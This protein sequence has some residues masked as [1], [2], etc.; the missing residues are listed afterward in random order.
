[1]RNQTGQMFETLEPRV[2]LD[3]AFAS[4][5]IVAAPTNTGGL[6]VRAWAT[7]GRMDSEGIL[8]EARYWV[9]GPGGRSFGDDRLWYQRIF[10]LDGDGRQL[11]QRDEAFFS[12]RPLETNGSQFLN[13]DGFPAGWW[14]A[15]NSANSEELELMAEIITSPS[16]NAFNASYRFSAVGFDFVTGDFFSSTG[17]LDI[18]I[19]D[20]EARWNENNGLM[21]RRLSRLEGVGGNS[22]RSREGDYF[23]L[24]ADGRTVLFADLNI[25]NNVV[26]IGIATR[27]VSVDS[28]QLAGG[29]NWILGETLNGG[30]N[31]T[32]IRLDLRS[33][34]DYRI[35]DLDDWDDGRFTTLGRGRWIADGSLLELRGDNGGQ[36]Y[37]FRIGDEAR[38]LLPERFSTPNASIPLFGLATR[39]INTLPG[40][41]PNLPKDDVVFSVPGP[42]QFNRPGVYQLEDDSVWY[43]IDLLI[44]AGGPTPTGEVESWID[45]NRL[46]SSAVAITD[47]GLALYTEN[48]DKSWTVRILTTEIAGAVGIASELEVMLDPQGLAHVT[49]LSST[50]EVL[51]YSQS[52]T[53]DSSG[54]AI[55]TFKNISAQDLAPAGLTTP[56]FTGLVSYATSWGGLNIAGLDSEGSIWSVWTAPAFNGTWTASN[57]T[58]AYGA[59]PLVGGLTVYLTSWQ[60]INI[61]GI[62]ADGELKVTWWVPA[63]GGTWAQNSLTELTGGPALVPATVTSYVSSWDGLNVAGI[64]QATGKL[65]VYWWSPAR[66]DLGW[67]IASLS[68]AL[69]AGSI[70]IS[71]GPLDG[72]AARDSSLNVFGRSEDGSFLRV[73]WTPTTGLWTSLNL[74][75][76]AVAR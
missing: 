8:T 67:A 49:G 5:G 13:A 11:R 45:S 21:P 72:I 20:N 56:A 31:L 30:F 3:N 36:N 48:I 66:Q 61:A 42:V 24:S 46:A 70:Q 9:D 16:Q 25:S 15:E 54:R 18:N 23:Y 52:A 29:Y 62:D 33:N 63:F 69:P 32:Q 38:T 14:F 68:D 17:N 73:F 76:A 65:M 28:A 50:G 1:M 10:K 39:D 4:V 55:W 51:Y 37:R 64:D 44:L 40:G 71:Q 57:L 2:V 58:T 43:A 53:N 12:S 19:S 60:G 7:E 22:L 75:T 27:T 41:N 59:D 26:Y 47:S 6:G 34:G 74:S 35:Y